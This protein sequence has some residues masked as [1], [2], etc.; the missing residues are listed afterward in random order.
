MR[1]SSNLELCSK[2]LAIEHSK[3]IMFNKLC[4]HTSLQNLML[5]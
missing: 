5:N 1:F 3:S 2:R 4:A